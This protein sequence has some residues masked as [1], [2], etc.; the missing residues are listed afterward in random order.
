MLRRTARAF[1]QVY[2]TKDFLPHTPVASNP[3]V[4]FDVTVGEFPLPRITVELFADTVPQLAENFRSLCTG[5]RGMARNVFSSHDFKKPLFYKGVP[6][7]RIIPGFIIQTGDII[8]MDGRGNES[9]Y[10]YLLPDESFEGKAGKNLC[11]TVAMANNG[12]HSN[13]SQFFFNLRDSPH[14][15]GKFVVVGQVV[16]GWP[17]VLFLSG[18]GSRSGLPISPCWIS[19]CGQSGGTLS[20]TQE[21]PNDDRAPFLLPGKEV[22]EILRPRNFTDRMLGK[23]EHDLK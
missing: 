6:F 17:S 22:G 2:I 20:E 9:S 10:G 18:R 16:D 14:L 3:L 8:Y 12:P 1:Q 19:E 23:L 13:G 11:G 4:F 21:I 5:E 15:D 7:H